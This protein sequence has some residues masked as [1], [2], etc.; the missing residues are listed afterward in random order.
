MSSADTNFIPSADIGEWISISD[1]HVRRLVN[2]GEFKNTYKKERDGRTTRLVFNVLKLYRY[3][4]EQLESV[5]ISYNSENSQITGKNGAQISTESLSNEQ[6]RYLTLLNA[7]TQ[8]YGDS[9]TQGGRKSWSGEDRASE[10][11]DEMIKWRDA[12]LSQAQIGAKVGKSKATVNRELRKLDKI[13]YAAY[14]TEAS[15]KIHNRGRKEQSVPKEVIDF[16]TKELA[17]TDNISD[18]IYHTQKKFPEY[19]AY[20]IRKEC[21]DIRAVIG[22]ARNLQKHQYKRAANVNRT[23]MP[24]DY[25]GL[26]PNQWWFMDFH[27][28]NP[29]RVIDEDTGEVGRVR[30]CGILDARTRR[31]VGWHHVVGNTPT[32]YDVAQ[33]V[34]ATMYKWGNTEALI[35]DGGSENWNSIQGLDVLINGL[36][37]CNVRL[38]AYNFRQKS[39]NGLKRL[40]GHMTSASEK[41]RE[42]L[43]EAFWPTM[44]LRFEKRLKGFDMSGKGRFPKDTPTITM[45]EFN[46][47]FMELLN[48]YHED[49]EHSS[50]GR[51]PWKEYLK[52]KNNGFSPV[53]PREEDLETYKMHFGRKLKVDRKHGYGQLLVTVYNPY[54]DG[55]ISFHAPDLDPTSKRVYVSVSED[56]TQA[57]IY[58]ENHNF[59]FVAPRADAKAGSDDTQVLDQFAERLEAQQRNIKPF[60]QVIRRHEE[61][62]TLY[63]TPGDEVNDSES[64]KGDSGAKIHSIIPDKMKHNP[65]LEP[66][67]RKKRSDSEIEE[68]FAKWS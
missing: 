26:R 37:N 27:I 61:N 63:E 23:Y 5:D 18:I 48:W 44:K 6:Q 3:C 57:A 7:I 45:R 34:L 62:D 68:L 14:V 25:S 31:L 28:I 10:L 54:G 55:R 49:H 51:T 32:S 33:M 24:M 13:G 38:D 9:I 50:I 17:I 60:K 36:S 15:K 41:P 22:D 8:K 46:G 65:D 52:A 2:N 16:L 58:D 42:N 64:N 20:K 40:G 67:E 43:I 29:V 59:L 47:L 19:S 30:T 21:G 53:M 11:I 39:K 12:G 35:V 66:V 56:Q 1:R 4:I